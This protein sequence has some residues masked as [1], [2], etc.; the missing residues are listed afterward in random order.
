MPI[1]WIL[2]GIGS[3]ITAVA[4]AAFW[5]ELKAWATSILEKLLEQLK[6]AT[7]NVSKAVV[8][9]VRK[10]GRFF[11]K[12]VVKFTDN[13]AVKKRK[14]VVI[15]E[16]MEDYEVS[17]EIHDA[18]DRQQDELDLEEDEEVEVEILTLPT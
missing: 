4:V 6:I 5:E 11:K 14:Q 7:Q 8:R 3:A 16:E 10:A 12:L 17:E 15:E 9:I 1:P 13:A 18:L 2:I